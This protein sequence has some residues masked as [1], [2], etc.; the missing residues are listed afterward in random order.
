[1]YYGDVDKPIDVS[2][3]SACFIQVKDMI[4]PSDS[5]TLGQECDDIF[6]SPGL[7]VAT[8]RLDVGCTTRSMKVL[9]PRL[10]S[11]C[12]VHLPCML[13]VWK[14]GSTFSATQAD[15]WQVCDRFRSV[16]GDMSFRPRSSTGIM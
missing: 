11:T 3:L 7:P 12:L 10:P 1:M 4:Q 13:G 14:K 9:E 15:D 5:W 16:D 6:N 2:K 8:I